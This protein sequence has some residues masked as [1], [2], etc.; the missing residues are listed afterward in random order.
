MPDDTSGT[1]D[2]AESG[3]VTTGRPLGSDGTP[4]DGP[5]LELDPEGRPAE[6]L[7]RSPRP[8]VSGPNAGTWATLLETPDEGD[9]DR[10]VLVQWLAPDATAPPGHVHPTT[11]TFEVLA[12]ELTVVRDGTHRVLGP[13]ES[14]TVQ[15]GVEHTFRNETDAVVAFRAVLP[16]MLTVASLYTV[17]GL[18]HEAGTGSDGRPGP[19]SG[20]VI[21]ADTYDDTT[22]T[23]APVPVQRLLWATVGRLARALG[24][25]GIDESYLDDQFWERHVEQPAL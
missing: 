11:E 1:H 7:R 25:D 19:L 5:A 13:G 4:T 15:P 2:T 14:V 23:V 12:G 9:I 6:L 16:S 10:P 22:V 17:W 20:L 8:L 3:R 18:D 21:M 24:V